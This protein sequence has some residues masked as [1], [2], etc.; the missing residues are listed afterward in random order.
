MLYS[1]IIYPVIYSGSSLSMLAVH[2]NG[3]SAADAQHMA[4]ELI[5]RLSHDI[6]RKGLPAIAL[7]TDT[8]VLTAAAND[9]SFDHIFSR[10]V[11]SL[12]NSNDVVVGISTSGN[13]P[14]IIKALE[15]A[16]EKQILCALVW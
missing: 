8:S 14:N 13:S 9:I 4:A 15:T 2:G 6:K 10:Q 5:V 1:L 3:G 16:K 12:G 11:E 7:T